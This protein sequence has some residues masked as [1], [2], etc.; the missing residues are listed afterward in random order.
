MYE[1]KF[2]VP[3]NVQKYFDKK[4]IKVTSEIPLRESEGGN[5]YNAGLTTVKSAITFAIYQQSDAYKSDELFNK[6]ENDMIRNLDHV[7]VV[8]HL[9]ILLAELHSDKLDY[10]SEICVI[11]KYNGGMKKGDWMG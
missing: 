10:K 8:G 2:K 9:G 4:E 3:T 7:H 6:R 11:N 5:I 1:Y